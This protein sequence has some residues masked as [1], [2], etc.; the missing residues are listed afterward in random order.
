MLGLASNRF[1][2]KI[3]RFESTL[4]VLTLY[5]NSVRFGGR[6]F[7]EGLVLMI[8]I[9]SLFRLVQFWGVTF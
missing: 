5:C 7:I 3:A 6:I 2:L 9:E 4:F 1:V 8:M